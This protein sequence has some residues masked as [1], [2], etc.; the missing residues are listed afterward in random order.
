MDRVAQLIK[1]AGE[2]RRA[3]W[4]SLPFSERLAEVMYRL[5][6][7]SSDA[8]GVGIYGLFLEHGVEGM[9]DIGGRP[10]AE[11]RGRRLPSTY[12]HEFGKAVFLMLM[13]TFHNP[14]TVEDLMSKFLV[15]FLERAGGLLKPGLKLK[16]AEGYVLRAM[17]NEGLSHIRRQRWETNESQLRSRDDDEAGP[18]FLDK[19]PAK[20]DTQEEVFSKLLD[21]H[22]IRLKLKRIH[23]SAEQY[24]RLMLE[25]YKDVEIMGN[26]SRGTPSMLSHPTLS[27]GGAVTPSSWTPNK[28]K[29]LQVLKDG[30]QDLDIAV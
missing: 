1:T 20:N 21:E 26:P 27:G 19:S 7:S 25:G 9:P 5:A 14:T 3:I 24:V 17:R 6:T 12:G 8:F 30:Y 11:F 4:A 18:G 16:E 13:R 28:K 15:R 2:I 29:I 23:P 10:A 22:S